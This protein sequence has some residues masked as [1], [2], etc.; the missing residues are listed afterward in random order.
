[1]QQK[2]GFWNNPQKVIQSRSMI[3]RQSPERNMSQAP[4]SSQPAKPQGIPTGVYIAGGIIVIAV[5]GIVA[6]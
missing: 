3:L 2:P 6:L 5:I 1:M 4:V